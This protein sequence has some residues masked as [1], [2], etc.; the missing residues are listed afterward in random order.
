MIASLVIGLVGLGIVGWAASNIVS[1]PERSAVVL[2]DTAALPASD[3]VLPSNPNTLGVKPHPL[4]QAAVAP[5]ATGTRVSGGQVLGTLT[6]PVLNREITVVEGTSTKDLK[7]GVGHFTQSVLPG[8]EDNCVLSGHRD[9]VLTHLDRVKKGDKLIVKTAAGTFTYKVRRIRI[10]DEDD[11]TV[12]VPT[13]HAVL[14]LSTCYPFNYVGNAPDRYVL[15][16]DL[17]SSN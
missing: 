1:T 11:R 8:M 10:V 6:I 16:A 17:V 7:R 5:K 2:A 12:I 9:T 15:V 3:A 13:K 4:A 14:T